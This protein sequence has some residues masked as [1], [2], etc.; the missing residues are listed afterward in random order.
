MNELLLKCLAVYDTKID[1]YEYHGNSSAVYTAVIMAR[2][3]VINDYEPFK[4][5]YNS[6][7]EIW[8]FTEFYEPILTSLIE[9]NKLAR[10]YKDS[11]KN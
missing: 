4:I 2:L 9:V 1:N 6:D 7:P 10:E 3:M 5:L 11:L 8:R